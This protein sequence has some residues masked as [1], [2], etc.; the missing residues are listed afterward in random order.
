MMRI[1][2]PS[3]GRA[4]SVG[5]GTLRYLEP[6]VQKE[7]TFV[8]PTAERDEYE[9]TIGSIVGCVQGAAAE[10]IADTRRVIGAGTD[11]DKFVMLDD[12]LTFLV[13]R[14]AETH[15]Q[16][17]ATPPDVTEALAMIDHK[18]DHYASV[19]LSARESNG[20]S[21]GM[22][23]PKPALREVYRMMRVMGY[24]TRDFLSVEHG[25]VAVME[26][27]DVQLQLLRSGRK[28]A[29]LYWWASGQVQTGNPGG[30]SAYRTL[31][32]H[33]AAANRLA[34]LHP[35]LVRVRTAHVTGK[36]RKTGGGAMVGRAEVTI[37]WKKALGFDFTPEGEVLQ[38]GHSHP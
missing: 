27:H 35:G 7:V 4:Y 37:Q 2:I 3:R 30:C 14:D 22:V 5:R 15:H 29:I 26:D 1:Y 18:L 32:V 33:N 6:H 17:M 9:A 36:D 12:D 20:L 19:G 21:D 16:K 11:A 28:N 34:E 8:V 10:G 13:R 25:R 31:A 24:R 38:K 23:G